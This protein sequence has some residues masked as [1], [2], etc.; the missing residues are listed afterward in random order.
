[1]YD[2]S[3][4]LI[5]PNQLLIT[6][7]QGPKAQPEMVKLLTKQLYGIRPMFMLVVVL[8]LLAQQWD[9]ELFGIVHRRQ[10][11]Y[12]WNDSSR[13]LFHYDDFWR[14]NDAILSNHSSYWLLP[15]HIEHRNFADIP[16]KK[17]SMYRKRYEMLK[18]IEDRIQCLFK[19]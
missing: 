11:K 16:S 15:K 6:S 5:M 18:H 13:L 19:K 12:R 8:K 7:I 14:E 3:F 10:A 17:R 9:C 4:A 1:M 2:A